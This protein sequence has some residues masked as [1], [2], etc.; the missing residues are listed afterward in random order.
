MAILMGLAAYV[1]IQLVIGFAVALR[2]RTN[3]DY[4]LAGRSIGYL[5]GSFSIFAT[6]FGAESCIGAAGEAYKRGIVAGEVDPFGY[7]LCLVVMGIFFA[8]RLW[9]GHYLTM[10]D[11]FRRRYSS[12]IEKLAVAILVPTSVIW[13]A[14]QLRAFGQVLTTSA[15]I[16]IDMG[17]T[18]ALII[19]LAY[20]VMGGMWAD[21]INDLIQGTALIIGLAVLAV[22]VF[23]A[24][25]WE[26]LERVPTERW[27]LFPASDTRPWYEVLDAWTVPLLNAVIS[28]ELVARALASRSATVARVNCLVAGGM[29][30]IVGSMPFLLGIVGP[31]LVP[32]IDHPE[33]I[34]PTLA[35]QY[36][37]GGMYVIFAGAI[38]SALLSTID[39]ALLV[40][41]AL[42]AN[43]FLPL[44]PGR[45]E[46]T[47]LYWSRA[48]VL[49]L[50]ISAYFVSFSSDSVFELVR[51]ASSLGASG[52]FVVVV[53]GLFT[54]FGGT[55]SAACAIFAGLG[56]YFIG[57][58]TEFEAS[59]LA[60]LAAAILAYIMA[61][62]FDR[63]RLAKAPQF[64]LANST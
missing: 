48:W 26:L 30:L 37:T 4:I 51:T 14:A 27:Q 55:L 28:Q 6:W 10:A 1:A 64:G 59:F 35:R 54:S 57:K 25:G 58:A 17:I 61:A 49:G 45:S 47:K 36:L 44:R 16:P 18:I 56:A 19:T 41:A 43:N 22:A 8:A 24:N 53:F 46:R 2:V 3:E 50:G 62:I 38:I 21:A 63:R 39:S 9:K 12:S 33:Q 11:I 7:A 15:D 5:F 29:Y 31:E 20:T 40:S 34:L 42:V 13:A 32:V 52:L 60:S 23:M